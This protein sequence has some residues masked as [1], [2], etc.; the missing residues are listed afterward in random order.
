MIIEERSSLTI[1][2]DY[3]SFL[4]DA[5]FLTEQARNSHEQREQ[6][7]TGHDDEGKDP[8]K[9]NNMGAELGQC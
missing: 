3:S 1:L 9:R 4:S 2:T 7:Q 8:L 6:D 5:L